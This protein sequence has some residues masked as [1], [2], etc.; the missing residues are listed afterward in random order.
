[1][2][3][4]HL[5]PSVQKS[6]TPEIYALRDLVLSKELLALVADAEEFFLI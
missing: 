3:R 6:G 1:M 5:P 2:N 4:A